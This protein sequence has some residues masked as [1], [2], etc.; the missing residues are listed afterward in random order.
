MNK[1]ANQDNAVMHKGRLE[2]F[3]EISD[4]LFVAD[5]RGSILDAN[6]S[7]VR[8]LGYP[9]DVLRSM[10]LTEVFPTDK[11]DEIS[12]WI[13]KSTEN[14]REQNSIPLVDAAGSAI[15]VENTFFKNVV[16]GTVTINCISKDAVSC[17]EANDKFMK[18]FSNSPVSMTISSIDTAEYIDVNDAFIE[19]IGY[20]KAEVRGNKV[21]DLKLFV[22][23]SVRDQI[24]RDTLELGYVRNRDVQIRDRQGYTHTG[25][26]SASNVVING[27]RLMLSSFNDMTYVHKNER[28]KMTI[29]AQMRAVQDNMPFN[30]WIKDINGR[31][32]GIN[33]LF[34]HALGKNAVDII[35][36][37]DIE[38]WP[39]EMARE[40]NKHDVEALTSRNHVFSEAV[41]HEETGDQWYEIYV[42]PIFDNQGLL[43][44]TA[45]ISKTITER[46]KLEIELKNQKK[47]LKSMIDVIPD[48]IFYKDTDSVYLGC[49]SAFS[50]KFIG[51]S[52]EEIVGKTDLHFVKDVELA[53]FFRE[54]DRIVLAA[55]ETISNEETVTLADGTVVDIETAKTPFFDE[56]GHVAGLIGVSRDITARIATQKELEHSKCLAEMSNRAK[57]VFLSNMNHELRTPLNAILGFSELLTRE[58]SLSE[59]AKDNLRIIRRSGEHLL[60]LINDVLN[61]SKIEAGQISLNNQTYDLHHLLKYVAEI[62]TQKAESN[63]LKFEMLQDQDIPQYVLGDEIK[64]RQIL[65]N[66]LSNSVKFTQT[67]TVRLSVRNAIK[68]MPENNLLE[69]KFTVADT[70]QGIEASEMKD[71]FTPFVQTKTGK[72]SKEGT[73]LGLAITKNFIELMGGELQVESEYGH[74]TVFM[75]TIKME[76]NTA[77]QAAINASTKRIVSLESDQPVFRLLIVDDIAD[78]RQLMNSMLGP[79]G[80]ELKDAQNGKEAIDIWKSWKPHLIWM[81]VRMPVMDGYEATKIIKEFEEA[82]KVPENQRTVIV[83]VSAS[84]FD[85]E[86]EHVLDSGFD[87]FVRK[88]VIENVLFEQM[89]RHIGLRYIYEEADKDA[90]KDQLSLKSAYNGDMILNDLK[91]LPPDLLNKLEDAADNL[92]IGDMKACIHEIKILNAVLADT[93]AEMANDFRYDEII[94]IL[95]AKTTC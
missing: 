71:L 74:G 15:P 78:N 35:G 36:K 17:Y 75:F 62:F 41:F 67:G 25:Y 11:H 26:F 46:K 60:S 82:D 39:P 10:T 65:M 58:K 22:D 80:F 16:D 48:L 31:Y 81:D 89:H 1:T 49:N 69:L 51:L 23:Q 85:E 90:C 24:V 19:T 45:G 55:T 52:E 13:Q 40:Y 8:K 6:A 18:I 88:P 7:A 2:F 5:E 14:Q 33:K 94:K 77:D 59:H 4:Y 38:L 87:D 66:L 76:K 28:E 30:S 61:L 50:D 27:K 53:N 3:N 34:E 12:E 44:G 79:Y 73:G 68:D 64:V 54:K 9:I 91:E 43:I 84:A 37:S 42:S 92:N 86:K 72:E 20:D 21:K 63:N 47:M 32:I 29:E 57:S 83:G 56:S 95:P 70:G 93:L